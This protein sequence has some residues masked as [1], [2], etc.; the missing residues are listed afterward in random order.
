[1]LT[2]ASRDPQVAYPG[3]LVT[4]GV[5]TYD[6]ALIYDDGCGV[7][8][9]TN[10]VTFSMESPG[11]KGTSTPKAAKAAASRKRHRAMWVGL[12]ISSL[13]PASPE[14][15]NVPATAEVPPVSRGPAHAQPESHEREGSPCKCMDRPSCEPPT[16]VGQ[17]GKGR[18]SFS[19]D[20]APGNPQAAPEQATLL[21]P[22]QAP[23]DTEDAVVPDVLHAVGRPVG[24]AR[25]ARAGGGCPP[26][27][28]CVCCVL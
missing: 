22:A 8:S 2:E 28:A 6:G 18:R 15:K 12:V 5:V 23:D 3:M 7:S 4:G 10:T 1:M 26:F 14:G 9:A 17:A 19:D 24:S 16:P 27:L 25:A 20:T 21:Q 11:S 13:E